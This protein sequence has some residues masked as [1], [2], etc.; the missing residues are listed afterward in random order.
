MSETKK[1]LV[2]LRKAL[3]KALTEIWKAESSV[4]A[5]RKNIEAQYFDV[6]DKINQI[7][8]LQG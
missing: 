5:V 7:E 6:E 4:K 8:G 1:E 2:D 3:G